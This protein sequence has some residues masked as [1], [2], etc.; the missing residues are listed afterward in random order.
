MSAPSQLAGFTTLLPALTLTA[1]AGLSLGSAP[2]A[3][4]APR[5]TAPAAAPTSNT[6]PRP[7]ASADS[8]AFVG[9]TPENNAENAR[10]LKEE[11]R[12]GLMTRV[13]DAKVLL[14]SVVA[15]CGVT[16]WDTCDVAPSR[17]NELGWPE[18]SF[19]RKGAETV[20]RFPDMFYDLAEP[21]W[22]KNAVAYILQSDRGDALVKL[23]Q[24]KCGSSFTERCQVRQRHGAGYVLT[25]KSSG[26]VIHVMDTLTQWRRDL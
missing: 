19:K 8:L 21:L 18:W 12:G 10:K 4:S 3:S 14:D 25:V 13:L 22:S 5:T 17:T 16:V 15:I 9:L 23:V 20:H 7:D 2:S 26:E 24:A 1:C 11:L 6:P